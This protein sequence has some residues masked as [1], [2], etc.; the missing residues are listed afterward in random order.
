MPARL[1]ARHSASPIVKCSVIV[2]AYNS[3]STLPLC[4]DALSHQTVRREEYEI[5]VVND[6][7]TDDTARVAQ[8]VDVHY[9]HQTNQGPACARNRGAEAALGQLILFTDSD[10]IPAPDWIAQMLK[11]FEDPEV[12][13]VKGAYRTRQK[14]LLAR[15]SQ[16]EFEDRYDLLRTNPRIDMIDT[17]SAAFRKDVFIGIGSFD[18]NFPQANNEDTEL[19]YRLSS[20]G[21]KMVFN[22][23]A[24]VLHKHPDSLRSYL[25]I[26][27]WRAYW[28]MIV[29][30]RFPQKAFKDSYTPKS[31][32]IQTLLMATSLPA[33][34]FALFSP[35]LIWLVAILWASTF[36]STVP[37]S[38]KTFMRDKQVGLIAP[39]V[40]FLRS[41]VFACGS[42]LGAA[43]SL[44]F[45]SKN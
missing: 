12:V 10:C 1:T 44:F 6:G 34:F 27:F 22:P 9:L 36:M 13:A 4:L 33:L 32:K 38:L 41:A 31:L 25:R 42:I 18:R 29:Y 20:A 43:R 23:E 19:S 21:Y 37:F 2:P 45:P 14:Q 17:Y 5:I 7:S 35:A 11:P 30:R 26:K 24:I 28:R 8:R 16:L 3:Q 39:V 15:F 40:V